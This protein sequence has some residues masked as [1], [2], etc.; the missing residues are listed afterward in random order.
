MF[1]TPEDVAVVCALV[2]NGGA[3]NGIK[4]LSPATV[5]MMTSNRLGDMRD[6]P[7]PVR[8]S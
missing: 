1:S 6:L 4:V 2:L 7:E 3:W 8:R 5:R